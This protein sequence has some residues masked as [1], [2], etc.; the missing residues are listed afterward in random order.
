MN[1]KNNGRKTLFFIMVVLLIASFIA[2]TPQFTTSYEYEREHSGE[3]E[4]SISDPYSYEEDHQLPVVI[5]DANGQHMESVSDTSANQRTLPYEANF[6]LYDVHFDGTTYVE[7]ESK[8]AIKEKVQID[9]RGHSSRINP[10]KQFSLKFVDETGGEKDVSILNMSTDHEWV[11][12]GISADTSLIRSYVA[13]Q[14]SGEIM[15]FAPDTRFVEVYIIDD[16]TSEV[17]DVSYR[18]VYMLMEKITRSSERVAITKADER[19]TDTSFIIERN[20]IKDGEHVVDRS[21]NNV[22][23]QM[24]IAEGI[25]K[26]KSAL[27]YVYPGKTRITDNQKEIIDNY[28][29]DFESTLHSQNFTDKKDGYRKYIDLKSFVD[30][31]IIND[32]FYNIDGGEDNTYFYRDIGG[33]LYAGPVWDFDLILGLPE[34]SSNSSAEGFKMVNTTWFDQLF[35]DPFFVDTYIKRYQFLRKNILS[36]DYLYDLIDDAVEELG[37]AVARNNAKWNVATSQAEDYKDQI[38]QIKDYIAKRANWMD[39][40]TAN[41][42]RLN[43]DNS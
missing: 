40:N 18:G 30:Y 21:W 9:I 34:D 41:L 29:H 5:I 24:V 7:E 32:F 27:S 16:Q 19:Y 15:A 14:A 25:I 13:Y 12:H 23:D 2:V 22:L 39:Q 3:R 43:E 33:R 6:S 26:K 28:I 20:K 17:N 35:K 8:P 38:Q 37:D 1:K 4:A 36:E 42:Y 31:A 10:K 11:L